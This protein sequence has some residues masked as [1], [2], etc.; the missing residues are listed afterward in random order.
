[1]QNTL[2]EMLK[3]YETNS[4]A[5]TKNSQSK[6]YDLKNY[7]TTFIP[8]KVN[9][10]TKRIRILPTADGSSPF[11]EI[12]G[13]KIQVDGENKTFICLKHE[14]KTAC[15][16]C[17]ANDALRAKNTEKDKE[18][19]KKYNARRMYVVKVID[20]DKEEEGVKFWRFNHDYRNQGIL[21]KI[22]GVLKAVNKDITHPET[23]RDLLIQVA[24]DQ[25]KIP[26]IQSITHVD[27]TPLSEDANLA[28]EWLADDRTWEDVYS[29]KPYEYLEI[30][31]KGGTPMWDKEAKK[32]VDKALLSES[33]S[34]ESDAEIT[35][36]VPD[37]KSNVTVATT[38]VTETTDN[39]A[40]GE[41]D[42]DLPF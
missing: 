17:E 41:E 26:I 34:N 12:Q 4:A 27:P 2:E 9:S 24:R 42:D 20:R 13:H 18:L 22:F 23:G 36:G 32:F 11:V 40:D 10:A 21:D 19:A 29:I 15:P 33:K 37:V 16:F 14:K 39:A 6:D 38:V 28:K 25:N 7:F 35:L 1:M 8:D 30:I 31:I 3:Q 5:P